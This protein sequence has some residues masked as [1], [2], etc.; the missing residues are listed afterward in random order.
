MEQLSNF[1]SNSFYWVIFAV[2]GITFGIRNGL[3]MYVQTKVD[4]ARSEGEL[5][6]IQML[7]V[8]VAELGKSNQELRLEISHL[9]EINHNLVIENENLRLEVRALKRHV[10][11]FIENFGASNG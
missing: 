1:L 10:E 7:R 5:D 2:V 3:S 4:K 9:R 6:V 8:Q 11:E